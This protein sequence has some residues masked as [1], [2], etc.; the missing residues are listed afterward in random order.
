[1]AGGLGTRL[2]PYTL[3]L[4][5]PLLPIRGRPVVDHIVR[6]LAAA[7]FLDVHLCTGYL[8][9]L[10][11]SYFGHLT[12]LPEGLELG[13][14]RESR[15]LGTAGPLRMVP[16]G[17][18][19]LL[20]TNGDVLSDLDYADLVA[21]HRRAGAAMTVATRV[22]ET[23][24]EYGVVAIDGEG[25][26]IGFE[27]KPVTRQCVN[28]GVY[29]YEPVALTYLDDHP[30]TDVPDLVQRLLRAGEHVVS[31]PYSGPWY[32]LGTPADFQHAAWDFGDGRLPLT[33]QSERA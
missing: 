27:E 22:R 8:G 17:P 16:G 9:E 19:P 32:D 25:R 6:R 14:T 24:C 29:V 5:K 1:M 7:G 28:I 23:I 12:D 2:S 30:P 13:F 18:G 11:A 33:V 21:H 15:P 20:V 26:V 3:A 10:V 31:Y 4:P